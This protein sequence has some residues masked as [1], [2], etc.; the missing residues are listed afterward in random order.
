MLI[1]FLNSCEALKPDWDKDAEPDARKRA[2]QNVEEGRGFG[3]G[4]FKKKEVVQ[5]LN[6]HLQIHYGEL[7]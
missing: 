3:T 5:I 7:L 4:M 6:L 2:R 1:V